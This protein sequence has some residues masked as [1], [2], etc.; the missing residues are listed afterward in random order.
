MQVTK[1]RQ[2]L[3]TR[4]LVLFLEAIHS[5][6]FLM[7]LYFPAIAKSTNA[8]R[9]TKKVGVKSDTVLSTVLQYGTSQQLAIQGDG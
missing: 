3:S 6:R 5:C 1:T 9:V 4:T 8:N 2:D 7:V